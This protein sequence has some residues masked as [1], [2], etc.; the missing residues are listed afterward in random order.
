[1]IK[2]IVCAS[3]A[4]LQTSRNRHMTTSICAEMRHQQ[5]SPDSD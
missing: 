2:A 3:R 1:V 5:L 4:A